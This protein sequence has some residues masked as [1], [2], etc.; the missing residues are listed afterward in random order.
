MGLRESLTT[1]KWVIE[2][3]GHIR[4][5]ERSAGTRRHARVGGRCSPPPVGVVLQQ[6]SAE[7]HDDGAR[8]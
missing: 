7:E 1:L 2:A 5:L 6:H 4:G 3:T 8:R